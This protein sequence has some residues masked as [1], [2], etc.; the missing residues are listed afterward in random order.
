MRTNQVTIGSTD[1]GRSQRFYEAFGLRLI[2]KNDHYLRF[3]CPD[4]AAP[5]YAELVE[6]VLESE[7][8]TLYFESEELDRDYDRLRQAGSRR[9]S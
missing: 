8:V 5:F 9:G 2:V 6:A 3:E 7:Q 4:G 1:L